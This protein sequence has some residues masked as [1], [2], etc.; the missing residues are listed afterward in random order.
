QLLDALL[1]LLPAERI[2]HDEPREVLRREA[3]DF[4]EGEVGAI[5]D[6]V[7]DLE[8]AR[9]VDTEDIARERLVDD[10]SLLGDEL[11]GIRQANFALRPDVT[12]LH[13]TLEASTADA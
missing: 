2:G 12:H 7:T 5:R 6:R 13:P 11:R 3:R 1:K 4:L 8:H 10:A 9:I